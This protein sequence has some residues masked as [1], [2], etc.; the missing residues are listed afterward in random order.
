MVSLYT[1]NIP[2]LTSLKTYTRKTVISQKIHRRERSL[3]NQ[4]I[5]TIN[6]VEERVCQICKERDI[7]D[8]L[9]LYELRNPTFY[10][11]CYV[12]LLCYIDHNSVLHDYL[13]FLVM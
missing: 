12:V 3:T 9:L 11:D 1:V 5:F 7:Q 8:E 13:F 4:G 10:V 2:K 6:M